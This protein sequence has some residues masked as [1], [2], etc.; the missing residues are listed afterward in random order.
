MQDLYPLVAIGLAYLLGSVSFAVVVSR[1]PFGLKTNRL[2][3][4]ACPQCGRA[5]PGIWA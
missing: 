4:G 5:I 2:A 1:A 3:G